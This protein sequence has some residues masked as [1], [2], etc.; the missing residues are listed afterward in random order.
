[1]ILVGARQRAERSQSG[2][3]G[4]LFL[5]HLSGERSSHFDPDTRGAL[6]NLSLAHT[7]VDII[8]AVLEGVAF[9]LRSALSY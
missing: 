8:R 9:S 2:A 5:P 3:R 6:V 1:M 4:V 7:P